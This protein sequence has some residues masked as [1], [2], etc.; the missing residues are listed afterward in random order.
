MRSAEAGVAAKTEISHI[1]YY[2]QMTFEMYGGGWQA[3]RN[4]M[5]RITCDI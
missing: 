1:E 2:P 4:G 3:R 5:S